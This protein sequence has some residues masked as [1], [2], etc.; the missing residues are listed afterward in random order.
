MYPV[1]S[2]TYIGEDI[3]A[4]EHAGAIVT[5]SAVQ[6]AVSHAEGVPPSRL[7]VDAVIVEAQPDIV[8][9]HWASHAYGELGR[10]ERHRQPFACRVHSFDVDA[11][12]VQRIMEHPLCVGVFAH[13]H[14]LGELPVGVQPLLPHRGSDGGDPRE[15]HGARSGAL[16][17]RSNCQKGSRTPD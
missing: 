2:E 4:L 7:D 1:I 9:M 17:V 10:M 8:L 6:D 16:S 3:D 13:P 5:V 14:H 11:E 15:P 12:R